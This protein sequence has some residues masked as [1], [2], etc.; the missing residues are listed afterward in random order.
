M[1]SSK[2]LSRHFARF[3]TTTLVIIAFSLP[4][5]TASAAA[6]TNSPASAVAEAVLPKKKRGWFSKVSKMGNAATRVM[7]YS[8]AK[9][10]ANAI[11]V[12]EFVN[13]TT[14]ES[15]PL[16]WFRLDDGV[17]GGQS[18]T[19]LLAKDGV[20]HFEGI[21]NTNGGGFTSIRTKLPPGSFLA[22]PATNTAIKGIKI[23]YRGD[24]KTYKVLLS[25]GDRGGPFTRV[26][27][28]QVDLPTSD[29]SGGDDDEDIWDE[30]TILFDHL[31]PAFGGRTQPSEDEKKQYTF[32]AA[33]M[34]ELGFMLSLRLSD[35]RPNPKETYGEG[36]FPFALL[37]QSITTVV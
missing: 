34:K 5:T 35:G 11:A 27:S 22:S 31:V 20:L 1:F 8:I 9:N 13:K 4:V 37:I 30:T 19:H 3:L 26:P 18:E 21:I 12:L 33:D 14:T 25:N 2:R 10:E 7:T 15:T 17:M 16:S 29:K 23:R 36:M 28:W 24:G 32:Q 6:E